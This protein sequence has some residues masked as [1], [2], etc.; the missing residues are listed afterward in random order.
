MKKIIIILVAFIV[1]L[2]IYFMAIIHNLNE[3]LKEDRLLVV[4]NYINGFHGD[5]SQQFQ[6][7]AKQLAY[8]HT[9]SSD[10]T[11]FVYKQQDNQVYIVTS[12]HTIKEH[13]SILVELYNQEARVAKVVGY[14]EVLDLAVLSFEVDYQV[15]TIKVARSSNLE[16]AEYVLAVGMIGDIDLKDAL[17]IGVI[18]NTQHIDVAVLE[19]QSYYVQYIV[20]NIALQKG[21]S[22]GPLYNQAK[23]LVAINQYRSLEHKNYT[24]SIPIEEASIVIDCLIEGKDIHRN[25]LEISGLAIAK[26]DNVM[27][28]NLD[29][30]ISL[31]S[32]IYV[33]DVLFSSKVKEAGLLKGDVI[34][35]IND[36]EI[37]DT[38]SL[39][40][41]NYLNSDSL[42]IKVLRNQEVLEL[43][44]KTSD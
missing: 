28:S 19:D 1:A 10:G 31:T 21:F 7:V 13:N 3:K 16:I 42:K 12:Y 22:G 15:E 43:E 6:D 23:E 36:K 35:S 41:A 2:N 8:I 9:V 14:D 25:G 33:Q 18:S 30:D 44:V 27:K 40:Q 5:F 38:I 39:R 37:H 20:S 26:M 34:I 11:G 17:A 24:L 29:L 4:E 32:G